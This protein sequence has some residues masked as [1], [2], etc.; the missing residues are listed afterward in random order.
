MLPPKPAQVPLST[1]KTAFED[2]VPGQV[3]EFGP[4]VVTREEI[5]SFAAEYDP[6]PMHLDEEGGRASM[7]GGLSAS[8]WNT[9]CVVF[10]M[11]ADGFL[12]NSL[13]MGS[14]AI[15]QVHWHAPV[16]PGDALSVRMTVLDKRVSKSRPNMGI[17]NLSFEVTNA[18]GVRV[19]TMASPLLI[20]MRDRSAARC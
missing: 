8:G 10:R 14:N 17:A 4:R 2:I 15:D 9:C 13:S 19:M 11:V 16:R 12:L 5:V 18:H 7:L 6:Q 3:F 1:R 20:G